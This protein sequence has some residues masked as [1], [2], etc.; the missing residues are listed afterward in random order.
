[1]AF[2]ALTMKLFTTYTSI[3]WRSQRV[4]K[5]EISP[6]SDPGAHFRFELLSTATFHRQN[7]MKINRSH[8]LEGPYQVYKGQ[9]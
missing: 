8:A 3:Q 4:E 6:L 9:S 7:L 1:M 5:G 2:A